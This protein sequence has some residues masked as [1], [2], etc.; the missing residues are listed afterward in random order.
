MSRRSLVRFAWLSIAAALAT[1]ALKTAAWWLTGSVGLLSDALESLVNL[2]AAVMALV[3]LTIAARPPDE[4]HAYGYSKAEYFSSTFEGALIALAAILI[5]WTAVARLL[6]PQPLEQVGL[7]LAVSVVAAAVNFGVALVLARAGRTHR[8]IALEADARH[9]MTDVWTTAGIVAGVGAVAATGWLWLDP[10]IALAVA[11]H[12]LWEG[13]K[14]VRRSAV[15]LL[16]AA[17]PEPERQAIEAVLTE[18]RARGIGFHAVRTRGAAHRSF[19][20]LHV[21]VPGG[22]TVQQAHDLAEEIEA[23][24]RAAVPSASVFTHLEPREDPTSYDDIRLDRGA[25][26]R[27]TRTGN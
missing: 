12:I 14:L 9:L 7:G 11:A 22:W 21:L 8:S 26:P 23:R 24:I 4:T 17:L 3:V 6:A 2:G 1:I 20:S 15:G 27:Q 18:F 16:D 5:G 13:Y 25:E 10:V 19:V